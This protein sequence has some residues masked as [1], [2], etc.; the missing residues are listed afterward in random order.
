MLILRREEIQKRIDWDHA[1]DALKE[2]FKAASAGKVSMPPVGYLGFP[3]ADGDC[4]IKYGHMEGD[5]LFVIK[6]STGFYR[7][8][9]TALPSSNGLSIVFSAKTGEPVA[10]LQD[11]GWLTDLRTGLA[12]AIATQIMCRKD[13]FR[14]GIVGTGTQ[15]RLQL[16]A[17]R[18]I[19]KDRNLE[20][21]VWGRSPEKIAAYRADM[22][23]FGIDVCEAASLEQLCRTSDII[24]TT[25]PSKAPLLQAAWIKPGTHITAVGAD[26][27][28]KQELAVQLVGRANAIMVDSRPQCTDHGEIATAVAMKAVDPAECLEIGEVL[29]AGGL[30]SRQE[31]DI[32]IADLTG[33]AVQDIAI[34]K[35]ALATVT[36][37]G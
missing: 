12:G 10:L 17:L 33:L 14:V 13:A 28:G 19:L 9:E 1:I 36:V 27:P 26:A 11:E 15:G 2:G 4:H 29:N 16:R 8:V 35:V 31:S 5:P 7:N 24:I 3:E 34:A 22:A 18:H 6:V 32:T 30:L 20:I 25:T 37:T 23:T 21:Q